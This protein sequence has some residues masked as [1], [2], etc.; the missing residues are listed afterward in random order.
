MN[1]KHLTWHVDLVFLFTVASHIFS[2]QLI[3]NVFVYLLYTGCT[4]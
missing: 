2:H 3:Y 1:V 4:K